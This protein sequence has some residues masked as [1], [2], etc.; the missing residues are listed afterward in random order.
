MKVKPWRISLSMYP[1]Y[2]QVFHNLHG[3]YD[4]YFSTIAKAMEFIRTVE[5][6]CAEELSSVRTG[7]KGEV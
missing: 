2:Y 5:L 1:G 3:Y 7:R 4:G 6:T